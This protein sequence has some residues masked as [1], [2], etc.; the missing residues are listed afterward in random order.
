MKSLINF[1]IKL[2]RNKLDSNTQQQLI[3]TFCNHYFWI[4]KV[5]NTYKTLF[6]DTSTR[7][8]LEK[9]AISFFQD[10]NKIIIE[11]LILQFCKITDPAKMKNGLN[12][13]VEYVVKYMDWSPDI[14][15]NLE[16]IMSKLQEF[17]KLIVPAR[18]KVIGHP[19]VKVIISK[20]QMIGKVII[21]LMRKKAEINK[22]RLFFLIFCDYNL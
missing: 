18:H 3:K 21:I 2:W 6:E 14:K 8:L 5:H 17:R 9:V 15:K 10:L 19:D 7:E 22:T 1:F 13:T 11:Y 16:S 4:R 12:L 20:N